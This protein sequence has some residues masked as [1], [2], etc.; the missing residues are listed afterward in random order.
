MQSA[1][2]M[3]LRRGGTPGIDFALEGYM[4]YFLPTAWG[5]PISKIHLRFVEN[6]STLLAQ[7]KNLPSKGLNLGCLQDRTITSRRQGLWGVAWFI[8]RSY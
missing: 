4:S 2:F 8:I 7:L 5:R 1:D 6:P 3:N